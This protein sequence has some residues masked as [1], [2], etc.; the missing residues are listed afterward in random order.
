M[1]EA[2]VMNSPACHA[3]QNG[4]ISSATSWLEKRTVIGTLL[5]SGCCDDRENPRF[6]HRDGGRSTKRDRTYGQGLN[7]GKDAAWPGVECSDSV[8]YTHLT[9]PTILRV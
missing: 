7:A 9:L 5:S 1:A 2:S 6:P 3:A 8:S 4:W